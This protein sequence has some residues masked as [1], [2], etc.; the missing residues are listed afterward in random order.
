MY[1]PRLKEKFEKE[2]ILN[3]VKQFSYKNKMQ[4]PKLEKIIVSMGIGSAMQNPNE[5]EG[6]INNLKTIT[7]Q[8][9]IVTKAKK[10]IAGF[11]LRTGMKIGLKVTLRGNRM[12]EFLDRFLSV[13]LPR[14]RDFR[15][16]SPKSMDKKG[17]LTVGVTEQ[18]VFSEIDSDKIDRTRGMNVTIV[19][20]SNRNEEG[21]SLLKY[22]G[23]PFSEK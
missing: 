6:A 7:G 21:F 19:T 15:G 20:S 3:M 14:T 18:I 22:F 10:S 11:K 4:V 17:N 23:V 16:I 1:K 2:I 12:Y 5:L 9:P 8:M 13:A